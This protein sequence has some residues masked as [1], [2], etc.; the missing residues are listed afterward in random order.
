MAGETRV[1]VRGFIKYHRKFKNAAS[2]ILEV[3]PGLAVKMARCAFGPGSLSLIASSFSQSFYS[4]Q[5]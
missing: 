2:G 1:C 3:Q 4:K 5:S